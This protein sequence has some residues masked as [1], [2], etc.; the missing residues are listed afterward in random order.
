[1]RINLVVGSVILL[2]FTVL[3]TGL[4]PAAEKQVNRSIYDAGN[5]VQLFVDQDLVSSSRNVSFQLHEGKKHPEN[6]LLKAE[7]P[8]EGWKLQIYGTVLFDKE[9]GIFKMWYFS[10]ATDEFP[11][12]STHYAT[13]TDGIHWEKPL[14]GTVKSKS[15]LK[16]NAVLNGYLL[17]S[18][19]KDQ[20]ETNPA[21]RYKMVCWRQKPPHGAHLM[22]SPDGLNW[23]QV[24]EKP[25]CRSS[26]VITGHYDPYRKE[27]IAFPKLVTN[28]RGHIRRCF[29]VSTSK[30]FMDW[31][32][33]RLTFKA[34]ARDD[35]G[36]M[37]RIES[38]RNLLDVADDQKL[39]RT[40]YYGLSAYP[41][42]SCTIVFPWIFTSNNNARYG[43]HEGPM[44]VQFASSRD[45][46]HW[47]R[48]FRKPIIP[49]GKKG[50][51]DEGIQIGASTAFEHGD[52]IRLYYSGAN[53]THGNPCLYQEKNTGRKT[54]YTCGIGLVSW[55][56]D[57]FVSVDANENRGSLTTVPFQ[58][59][60]K[61]L[62]LNAKTFQ[63]GAIQVEVRDASGS[64]IPG[65]P[66]LT[67]SG[68]EIRGKVQFTSGK[69]D[70]F[71][72][73]QDQLISLKFHLKNCELYSYG[74]H[75]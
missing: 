75:D 56:K 11:H 73:L 44:E 19:M 51:W 70:D 22:V 17:A 47:N 72:L 26:D 18:V 2:I 42:E 39:V 37:G 62:Y 27:Y 50:D 10:D 55:K 59:R 23:T 32:P 67:F 21:Q 6:P 1:M 46:T 54:K 49:R 68:N 74:F 34:D 40:E 28:N 41:H 25:F 63:K 14:F 20:Q 15:G 60:G 43:N 64:R 35:Y 65:V 52:E 16:H 12:F 53:Y 8:F 13:S 30:N 3:D 29:G 71:S 48:S 45:L 31:T 24:N 38:A 33:S 5:R 4:V 58:F 61:H 36:S 66:L 57:R 7:E 69:F 9:E